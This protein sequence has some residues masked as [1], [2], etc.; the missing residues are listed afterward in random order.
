[1]TRLLLTGIAVELSAVVIAGF[2]TVD[3]VA[4]DKKSGQ[5]DPQRANRYLAEKLGN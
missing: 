1:M 3:S 5:A 2:P 4:A